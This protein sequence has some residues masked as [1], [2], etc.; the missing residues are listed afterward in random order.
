MNAAA[1]K[2]AAVATS[3][4]AALSTVALIDA[5]EATDSN[6]DKDVHIVRGWLLD[7][8]EGRSAEAFDAWMLSN[9]SSPRKFYN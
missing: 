1:K 9:E 6:S 7:A 2:I 5:F 4:I 8:L 3:K